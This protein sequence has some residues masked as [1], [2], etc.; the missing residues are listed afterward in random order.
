MG[1]IFVCHSILFKFSMSELDVD[2][3]ETQYEN[4]T[5]GGQLV[6]LTSFYIAKMAA[7]STCEIRATVMQ[8][9]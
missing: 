4:C 1:A 3:F 7:M 8:L 2:F 6:F 9:I 5:T